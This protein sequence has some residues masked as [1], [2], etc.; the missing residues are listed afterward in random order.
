[1]AGTAWAGVAYP[2][3]SRSV[4]TFMFGDCMHITRLNTALHVLLNVLSSLLLS[5]GNYCMQLLASPTR[6]EADKAHARGTVLDIGV[7]SIK[8][9]QHIDWRRVVGWSVIGVT[10]MLLHLL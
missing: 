7:P 10:A 6:Q 2:P 1:M 9:L 8:N 5:T 4:S 3:D